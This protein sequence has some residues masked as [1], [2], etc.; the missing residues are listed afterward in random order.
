MKNLYQF[1]PA[2]EEDKD[3]MMD[4]EKIACAQ[5]PQV[6]ELWDDNY[7]KNHYENH[8]RPKYVSIIQYLNKSIGAL[9]V[10]SRRKDITILYLYIQPEFENKDIDISVFNN[11]IGTAKEENKPV[12][13]C[14]FKE[15][16]RTKKICEDLGFKVFAEDDIRWR[17]K[18]TP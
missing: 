10:I 3:F 7:Q 15:D 13:T 14:M 6:M 2:T 16:T 17:V 5:Y 18:W 9:S 12:M 8:F 11:V 1:R 4:L